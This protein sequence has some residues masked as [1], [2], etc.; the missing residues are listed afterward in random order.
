MARTKKDPFELLEGHPLDRLV[1][2]DERRRIDERVATLIEADAAIK[3]VRLACGV[4]QNA[5]A[6]AMG[7]TKSSVA[8]LEGRDLD[9]IQ[10]GTLNRYFGALGF[11]VRI[12]LERIDA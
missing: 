12:E 1:D 5:V 9:T 8:Q 6:E 7:V 4:A 11:K 3:E 2:A 10:V